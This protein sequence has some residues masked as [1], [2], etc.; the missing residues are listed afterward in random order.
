MEWREVAE[1]VVRKLMFRVWEKEGEVSWLKV[2]GRL[3][4]MGFR[5]RVV[6]RTGLKVVVSDEFRRA[7]RRLK[8]RWEEEVRRRELVKEL[9][10]MALAYGDKK[11][12]GKLLKDFD[13]YLFEEEIKQYREKL[14]LIDRKKET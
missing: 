4:G 7:Y 3:V 14:K 11:V 8:R 6:P 10:E 9:I 5:Y 13:A 2:N 1:K 12:A